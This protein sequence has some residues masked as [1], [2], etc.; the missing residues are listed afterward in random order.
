MT[1]SK[2]DPRPAR[3]RVLVVE[4]DP[5]SQ[6]L[7]RVLLRGAGYL[8]EVVRTASIALERVAAAPPAL[9]LIDL[10]LP[11]WDGLWLTG[12]LKRQSHTA[13]IPVVALASHVKL[14][15]RVAALGTGCIGFIS[16][17]IDTRTFR[18]TVAAYLSALE[19]QESSAS[20]PRI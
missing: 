16:K 2:G 4:D 11:G 19:D 9:I 12:E 8:V 1:R 10:N 3:H 17:P 15:D 5:A 14:G 7:V 13:D 20:Q 6:D 18:A